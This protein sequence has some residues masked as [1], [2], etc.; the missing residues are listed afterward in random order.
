MLNPPTVWVVDDDTD[1]QY[2][3]EIAFNQLLPTVAVKQLEDGTELVPC[4]MKVTD[5]PRLILLDLNMPRLNGFETLEA[6]RKVPA[7]AKIP[8][9]ILTTSNE[10]QDKQK[11]MALGANGFLTKPQSHEGIVS[12]LRQLTIDWDLG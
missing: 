2:L 6:V 3:V 5:L 11:S 12:M 10:D 7:F 1:D 4:L 8:V 9:V